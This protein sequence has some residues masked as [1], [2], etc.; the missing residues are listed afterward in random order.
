MRILARL[1][2]ALSLLLLAAVALGWFLLR[3]SLPRLDGEV[4]APALEAS[5]TIERDALGVATVSGSS[6]S[7]VAFGTGYVHAQDR[8]F[9]MDLARRMA[10]GRLAELLGDAALDL[11]RRN[12]IH[13]FEVV[14]AEVLGRLPPAE[15]EVIE[16]YAAGVNAGLASLRV[17]PFEYLLLRQRPQAWGAS[18][19]L[20]VVYAMFLQLNDSR[21]EADRQRGLLQSI[22]PADVFRFV[23]SV[24]PEWEAP[25]DGLVTESAPVPGPD[26]YDLQRFEGEFRDLRVAASRAGVE[27]RA[28]GSNNWA[29]AGNR[30]R[31]GAGLV[32][33]DMH[34]GL[35]VPNTWYRARLVVR[36]PGARDLTGVTLPGAPILVAG[37]NGHVA[38]GFTNSYGDWSD[39][40]T[41]DR[42]ADG[43]RYRG[44]EGWRP[45]ARFDETVRSSSGRSETVEVLWTEWGPLLEPASDTAA[46]ALAWT[47]HDSRAANL[48][49]LALEVAQ[50]VRS[51]LATANEIGGPVQNF[52]V[53]DRQGGIGWTLLG[54]MPLRGEGYDPRV[55]SDW[56]DA[57]A[58][59]QG[60]REPG[61]YP[62]VVDPPGGRL[63]S[64]NN[65]VVG[66]AALAAIGDGSPDRGARAQQIRDA[67]FAIESATERDMLAIQLD[68]RALFLVRWRDLLL[69]ELDAAAV[70]GNPAREEFRRL[71]ETWQ[72]RAAPA[73]VGYLMVRTFH[74]ALERRIF[75][76]LTIEARARH[77]LVA[78]RVPRQFEEAA[79]RLVQ[80]RPPHLLDPRFT[81]WDEFLLSVVD[82]AITELVRDCGGLPTCS[83]GR[84][85]VVTMQHPLSR[86][87]PVLGRWL[88][89]PAEPMGGDHDMPH[90]QVQGFG[91]SQRFAVSPGRERDGYFHMPGGQSG[92]PLSPHYRAGHEAWV[93]GEATPFL[94]GPAMYTLSLRP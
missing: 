25:I 74:E 63:W 11:D 77:P 85:N 90:V 38:W 10:S 33:N 82:E 54:R 7:D 83:W 29:V 18:D 28:L 62:R 47:A 15:R 60:W 86:A 17:R 59:W 24:A 79:W 27:P 30:T 55:P 21:G 43:L 49:W 66:G 6:R 19:S 40:V 42:S 64:A 23:Y 46:L 45:F 48:R 89:M 94:P 34:L 35:G 75:E 36:G 93:R 73:S 8:Y 57:G 32:A 31:S 3:S 70:G 61:Q 44:R 51:A 76:A 80:E 84:R 22:L 50:D 56:T 16:S 37:S 69:D 26:S 87:L 68:D 71:V 88:D 14:A 52:V 13:R 20:L 53:A 4:V 81:T 72:P 78:W 41:V 39:L 9:Q 58:G 91:A 5:V 92:H 65:R 67:L 2:A 1:L 12:R